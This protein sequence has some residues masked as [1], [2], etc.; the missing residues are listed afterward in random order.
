MSIVSISF[1]R[2]PVLIRVL[3]YAAACYLL[4]FLAQMI[5]GFLPGKSAMVTNLLLCIFLLS[6]TRLV[7]KWEG[8]SLVEVTGLPGGRNG[9]REFL[10]GTIAGI[11][12]LLVTALI[13]KLIVGFTWEYKNGVNWYNLLASSFTVFLSAFAQELAFR[14]YTFRLMLNRWGEWSA[15]L[16]TAILFG[17][18]HL[19]YGMPL[20]EMLFTML[21]TGAGS[22]LF[23]IAVI[24]TRRLHLATGIHFGWNY[25]QSILPRH[26]SQNSEGAWLVTGGNFNL[27]YFT[28]IAPYMVIVALVYFLIRRRPIS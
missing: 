9:G 7:L 23:G 8:M 20:N 12:M 14:G 3:A 5:A 6:F 1:A 26:P 11:A 10:V 18:M 19:N 2:L 13:I 27:S 28:W 22:F 15:Q 21:T 16:V 17:C 4:V 25:L 24:R